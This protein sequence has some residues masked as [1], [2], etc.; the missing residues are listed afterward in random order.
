MDSGHDR[1]GTEVSRKISAREIVADIKQGSS[2]DDLKQ[3]YSLSQD[4]LEKVISKLIQAGHIRP[5]ELHI[6]E[7]VSPELRIPAPATLTAAKSPGAQVVN[8]KTIQ[9]HHAAGQK[10]SGAENSPVSLKHLEPTAVNEEA[11]QKSGR[12]ASASAPRSLDEKPV[13]E[14][15]KRSFTQQAAQAS[16]ILFLVTIGL[17]VVGTAATGNGQFPFSGLIVGGFFVILLLVGFGLGVVGCV[18]IRCHGAKTTFVPGLIG[19]CLN[20]TILAAVLWIA[21]GSFVK[22]SAMT[23]RI[24]ALQR[25]AD[26]T[27]SKLPMMVDKMTRLDKVTVVNASQIENHLTLVSVMK[28]KI[29]MGRFVAVA[30][31]ALLEHYRGDRFKMFRENKISVRMTYRDKEGELIASILVPEEEGPDKGVKATK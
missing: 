23:N 10:Y 24:K 25:E 3:K 5:G 18:G 29:E 1:G 21:V 16:W 17:M 4:Q 11:L 7:N 8:G 28:N 22:S 19:A 6:E 27:N 12:N 2:N 13:S 30:R 20:A 15:P 26:H 31:S 14:K 9:T